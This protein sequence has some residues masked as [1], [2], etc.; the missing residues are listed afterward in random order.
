MWNPFRR[1]SAPLNLFGRG[2]VTIG[3]ERATILRLLRAT[4]LVANLHVDVPASFS[5]YW[6]GQRLLG[7]FNDDPA[8]SA[9][10]AN[11][12]GASFWNSVPVSREHVTPDE[13]YIT[14][15]GF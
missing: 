5:R 6:R 14:N 15:L 4:H 10:C 13:T 1:D 3:K 11:I 12:M 9:H 2:V 7:E 8:V